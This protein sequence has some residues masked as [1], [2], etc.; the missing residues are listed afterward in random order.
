MNVSSGKATLVRAIP[1]HRYSIWRDCKLALFIGSLVT[2]F[3]AA[4][5]CNAQSTTPNSD[6]PPDAKDHIPSKTDAPLSE[7]EREMLQL[8]KSL[9]D[10]VAK[11]EAQAAKNLK[12]AANDSLAAT[13]AAKST[14]ST[15]KNAESQLLEASQPNDSA[16]SGKDSTSAANLKPHT[17]SSPTLE[18]TTQ[19][20]A[21]PREERRTWGSYT[22][23]FGFKVADTEHGDM[24]VSIF[25][26]ARY[27]NQL[28]L[29]PTYTN[30]FG[31]TIDVKQRQDFQLQ[32]LQIKFLGWMLDPK[33][34]Y[35]LWAWTSN[36]SMGLGAQVVLAG[37][38]Q[39]AF[40][41][42][43]TIG[44]GIRSLPGTRSVEGNF[45]FWLSVDSRLIADE[46]FRPSYTTGIWALGNITDRLNYIAML[47]DNLSQLG[48]SATQ[49][50]NYLKT[51]SGALIWNPTGKFGIG[52]GDFENHDALATR[53]GVHFTR[54]DENKQSQPN[55]EDFENTQIRLS[56][57]TIVFTP[58][59]F[60]PG[61]T[62]SD[63][64]YKMTS[65]DGGLKYHGYSLDAEYFLRWLS[66]F[67]DPAPTGLPTIFNHGFQLQASAMLI[68]KTFQLYLGGSK[69]F[70]NFSNPYD[71]RTGLNWFPWKNRV[72]RWNNEGLYVYKSPVGYTSVPYPLGGKGFIFHSSLE[73]AF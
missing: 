22:P 73:L 28:A 8:I 13:T 24:S 46:F 40:D 2:F 18:S 72:I 19:N 3:L 42:H 37:T 34:R 71:F 23:N 32:K 64:T 7:R 48:V 60:G 15:A 66:N 54:S 6:A 12:D 53:L 16:A 51:F 49:L 27:L 17:T 45:P 52:F 38:L 14:P 26:Y 65:F 21:K 67:R 25:T 36:A 68:P 55:A 59:L 41:D 47:G 57:G 35:F 61:I 4:L 43:V 62:I 33:F 10:R 70:G 31:N 5:I 11:L 30:A 58:N 50:P 1:I 69:I 56:D 44:A 29:A 39:Y 63:V 9:Q 20:P